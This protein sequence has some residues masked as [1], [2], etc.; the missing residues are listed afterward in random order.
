MPMSQI[1]N[2]IWE[3]YNFPPIGGGGSGRELSCLVT[4]ICKAKHLRLEGLSKIT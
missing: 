4:Q 3:A 2:S 1:A